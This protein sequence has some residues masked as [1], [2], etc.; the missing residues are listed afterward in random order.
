[1]LKCEYVIN[2]LFLEKKTLVYTFDQKMEED[3]V[4]SHIRH[5]HISLY[6]Y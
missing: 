3:I 2:F 5:I 1:M 6:I 4:I